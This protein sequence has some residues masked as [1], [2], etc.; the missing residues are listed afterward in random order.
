MPEAMTETAHAS[1]RM[2]DKAAGL[3]DD[4][5]DSALALTLKDSQSPAYAPVGSH[6]VA[7]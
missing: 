7:E 5:M 3:F 1:L 4:L 6:E 2:L